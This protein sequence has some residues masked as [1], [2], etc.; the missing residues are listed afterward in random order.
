MPTSASVAGDRRLAAAPA[1][2]AVEP[3]QDLAVPGADQ[4]QVA[5]ADQPHRALR[6]TPIANVPTID[7]RSSRADVVGVRPLAEQAVRLQPRA[8]RLEELAREQR[9]DARHPRVGRLRDDHVVLPRR[10][11]QVG[12]AVADDQPD[13]GLRQRAAVLALEEVRRLDDLR[14]NLDD[15][16][17]LDRAGRQRGA[18]P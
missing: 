18:R 8:R 4:Q 3:R 9:R 12:S 6:E 14:R 10:Q 7:C 2:I 17:A 15:V 13:A 1:A 16:G 5:A 11:Q